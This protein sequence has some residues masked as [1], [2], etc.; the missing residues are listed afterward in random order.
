MAAAGGEMGMDGEEGARAE[1][2]R[3]LFSAACAV[4]VVVFSGLTRFGFVVFSGLRRFGRC[5]QRLAPFRSLFSAACAVSVLLCFIVLSLVP[6]ALA[7]IPF[8]RLDEVASLT[9]TEQ[10]AFREFHP[11]CCS[12]PRDITFDVGKRPLSHMSIRMHRTIG[13]RANL[14]SFAITKRIHVCFFSSA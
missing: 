12:F 5:F 9:P 13:L 11:H 14:C 3:S 8:A 7:S 6:A 10:K 1:A 2:D 4:S